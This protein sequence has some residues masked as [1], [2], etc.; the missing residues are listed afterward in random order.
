MDKHCEAFLHDTRFLV[1]CLTA[2]VGLPLAVG[3]P[4]SLEQALVACPAVVV[5]AVAECLVLGLLPVATSL[6]L[7]S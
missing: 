5:V 4:W 6:E 7:A 2:F 3:F 1:H